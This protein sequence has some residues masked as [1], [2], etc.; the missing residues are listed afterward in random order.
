M[1][2]SREYRDFL[3]REFCRTYPHLCL[4]FII[5]NTL[6]KLYNVYIRKIKKDEGDEMINA[7]VSYIWR[8]EAEEK[9]DKKSF[10]FF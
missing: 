10:P 9:K 4:A 1:F 3:L 8:K 5:D 2:L 7:F 6:K